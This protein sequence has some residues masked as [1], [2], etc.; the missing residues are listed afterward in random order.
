[1]HLYIPWV[2]CRGFSFVCRGFSFDESPT[3]ILMTPAWESVM[4]ASGYTEPMLRGARIL[5]R[6]KP[7][8]T[9]GLP[10]IGLS[11]G[12][13]LLVSPG[14][15]WY[16][17]LRTNQA[18]T[19]TAIDLLHNSIRCMSWPRLFSGAVISCASEDRSHGSN[20]TRAYKYAPPGGTY[21]NPTRVVPRTMP[22]KTPSSLE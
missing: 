16:L 19:M 1:M 9:I 2:L 12:P 10:A 13:R 11:S 5:A 20:C 17:V 3:V 18:L 22:A 8:P 4:R 21:H 6:G 14:R 7:I 15:R